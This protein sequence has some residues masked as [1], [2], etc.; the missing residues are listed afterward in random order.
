MNEFITSRP[1]LQEM[2]RMPFKPKENDIEWI[3]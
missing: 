3:F 1:A 2:F